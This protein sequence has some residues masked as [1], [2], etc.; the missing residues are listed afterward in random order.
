MRKLALC[1][2]VPCMSHVTQLLEHVTRPPTVGSR[3]RHIE[4]AKARKWIASMPSSVNRDLFIAAAAA[5][6]AVKVLAAEMEPAMM[7]S[8]ENT[9]A[10]I[11]AEVDEH[12]MTLWAIID[13]KDKCSTDITMETEMAVYSQ[14]LT[15]VK[16]YRDPNNGAKGVVVDARVFLSP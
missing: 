2:L 7:S 14:L 11:L 5:V 4:N 16:S 15:R 10:L 13:N 6:P 9:V 1:S 12:C 3:F 8:P